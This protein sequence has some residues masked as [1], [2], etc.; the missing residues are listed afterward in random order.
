[1]SENPYPEVKGFLTPAMV[2]ALPGNEVLN[3][4]ANPDDVARIEAGYACGYCCAVFHTFQLVCPVCRRYTEV[5]KG[6]QDTPPEWQAHV[7]ERNYGTGATKANTFDT[8]MEHV[9]ADPDVD[10][11]TTKQLLP[12]RW[13]AGRPR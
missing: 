7:D 10:H 1:V 12:S 6:R 13:G 4:F 8:F 5:T 11:V 9:K 2:Q 3:A